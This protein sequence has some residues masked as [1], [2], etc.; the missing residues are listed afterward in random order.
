ME[1]LVS[2]EGCWLAITLVIFSSVF[3]YLYGTHSARKLKN[4][5]GDLPGPKPLPFIGNLPDA[6]KHKGQTHLQFDEYYR[7]YG[8]LFCL[9]SFGNTALMVADPEM[10]KHILVK[11]FESFHD[12]TVSWHGVLLS[13]LIDFVIC[14]YRHAVILVA[15]CAFILGILISLVS[16]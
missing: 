1:F 5:F 8:R 14:F 10:V 6:Y 7:K 12:R 9:N 16:S 4:A 15:M 13:S 2:V 11:D 3:L